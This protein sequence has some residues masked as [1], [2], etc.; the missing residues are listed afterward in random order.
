MQSIIDI[1]PINAF[2][3]NY[4]WAITQQDNENVA[5]VDPGDADV[6]IDF[7]EKNKLKLCA[8]LVTHHHN[9]HVDGN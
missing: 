3:D 4:I 6:C 9:D 8:I 7:I 2:S 1:K 5:L